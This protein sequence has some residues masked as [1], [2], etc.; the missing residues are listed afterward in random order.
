VD[1]DRSI[2][3]PKCK[4]NS[5]QIKRIATYVYTYKVD[6]KAS[7]IGT[8]KVEALPFV[9]DNREKANSKEYIY[10][11]K[12]GSEFPISLDN[13]KTKIDF[14]IIRKAVRA[15]NIDNPQFLG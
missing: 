13:A 14:T 8:E 10:C 7:D 12:C 11:D 1:L 4:N 6:V 9:F 5:F 2:E 15:D 3:C